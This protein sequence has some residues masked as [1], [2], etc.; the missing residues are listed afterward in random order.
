MSDSLPVAMM[1]LM[2]NGHPKALL[3]SKQDYIK[4]SLKI[5]DTKSK[6]ELT[7]RVEQKEKNSFSRLFWKVTMV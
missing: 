6:K 5:V 3:Y 4:N 1:W 7:A 2:N